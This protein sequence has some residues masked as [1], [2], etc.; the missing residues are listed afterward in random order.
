MHEVIFDADRKGQLKAPS[1][2]DRLSGPAVWSGKRKLVFPVGSSLMLWTLIV[3]A[4]LL[5]V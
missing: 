1:L 3:T 4:Y 2:R 5:A